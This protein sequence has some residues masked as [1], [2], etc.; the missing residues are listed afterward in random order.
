M[1]VKANAS[2]VDAPVFDIA[3]VPEALQE[4]EPGAEQPVVIEQKD[5]LHVH[6]DF[7]REGARAVTA[8]CR[9]K[10]IHFPVGITS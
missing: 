4:I 5:V 10:P 9:D 2:A 7:G 8:L 3:A 1:A 6:A